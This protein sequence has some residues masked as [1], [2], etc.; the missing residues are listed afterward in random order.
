VGR[1][2]PETPGRRVDAINIKEGN[3]GKNEKDN[4]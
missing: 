4:Q 2:A 1:G 3:S